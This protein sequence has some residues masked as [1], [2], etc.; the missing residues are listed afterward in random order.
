LST[1]LIKLMKAVHRDV[2]MDVYGKLVLDEWEVTHY[3]RGSR[4]PIR[5]R[6]K[7]AE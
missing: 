7:E 4:D 5:L 3:V 6:L 2:M 1:L